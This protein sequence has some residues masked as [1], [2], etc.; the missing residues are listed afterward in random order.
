MATPQQRALQ[1][2]AN[3]LGKV[4][5]WSVFVGIGA[6]ALQTSLYT[7]VHMLTIASAGST[8]GEVSA[9]H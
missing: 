4:G 9:S 5:K 3:L 6:S 2:V 7:G 1:Q 8:R